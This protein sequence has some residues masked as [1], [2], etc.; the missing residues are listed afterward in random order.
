MSPRSQPPR[1]EKQEK[2]LDR[3]LQRVEKA[4]KDP[5]RT[6]GGATRRAIQENA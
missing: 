6:V 1:T 5:D 2:A 4:G 3:A